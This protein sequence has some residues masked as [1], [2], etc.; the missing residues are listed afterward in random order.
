VIDY[1]T[2]L[3]RGAAGRLVYMSSFSKTLAPGF[4]VA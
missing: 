4:R 2:V 1:T 3:S